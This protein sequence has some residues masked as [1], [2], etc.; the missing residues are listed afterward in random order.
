MQTEHTAYIVDDDSAALTS[1]AALLSAHNITNRGFLSAGEF[2]EAYEPCWHG[3]ALLDIR[4]PGMSGIELQVKMHEMGCGLP[5]ILVTAYGDVPLA[6]QGMKAGAVDFIEKPYTEE[7]LLDA[8]KAAFEIVDTVSVVAERQQEAREK[9]DR[10]S[11]REKDVLELL[12]QGMTN[13]EAARALDLSPRT[14]EIHR[15]RIRE[16]TGA[17][18]LSALIRLYGA[19]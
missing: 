16:K 18:S 19:A 1:M 14:V 12:V 8:L 11:A 7:Q 3:C 15:N 9:I 4:M 2:L 17:K 6:V 10:L 13:K 5:V